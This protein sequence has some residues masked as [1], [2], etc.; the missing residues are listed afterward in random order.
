MMPPRKK[1]NDQEHANGTGPAKTVFN[2]AAPDRPVLETPRPGIDPN[3]V[4]ET[5]DIGLGNTFLA[6]LG[7]HGGLQFPPLSHE[8]LTFDLEDVAG[9]FPKAGLSAEETARMRRILYRHDAIYL[10]QVDHNRDIYI[11]LAGSYAR[12][13]Y[14]TESAKAVATLAGMMGQAEQGGGRR[15][16]RDG[17]E[18]RRKESA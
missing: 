10:L 14:A 11:Q 13:R 16:F 17:E 15:S 7:G 4:M 2:P 3:S 1:K 12:D 5:P 8:L 6:D 18:Q 9:A